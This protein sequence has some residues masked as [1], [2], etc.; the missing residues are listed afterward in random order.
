MILVCIY[1]YFI[2]E[3]N[4]V[5]LKVKVFMKYIAGRLAQLHNA[6]RKRHQGTGI[7]P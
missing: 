7:G 1:S 5:F 4:I 3:S 2:F 6:R